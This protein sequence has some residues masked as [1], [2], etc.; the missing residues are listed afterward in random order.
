VPLIRLLEHRF[1]KSIEELKR[2][3]PEASV[4]DVG[5]A[6]DAAIDLIGMDESEA[7]GRL[8][9]VAVHITLDQRL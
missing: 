7:D 3:G 6:Q 4:E 9:D 5:M 1:W 8:S 2:I